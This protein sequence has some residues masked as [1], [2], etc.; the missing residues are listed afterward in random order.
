MKQN[1]RCALQRVLLLLCA[2][3][4]PT[5][6]LTVRAVT[7]GE[8]QEMEF[9]TYEITTNSRT[10]NLTLCF[11]PECDGVLTITDGYSNAQTMFQSHLYNKN[12]ISLASY[13]GDFAEIPFEKSMSDDSKEIVLQY[14]LKEGVTYYYNS[15]YALQYQTNGYYVNATSKLISAT[16][17]WSADGGVELPNEYTDMEMDV[18]YDNLQDQPVYLTFTP[19]KDGVLTAVQYGSPMLYHLVTNPLELKPGSDIRTK[20][21]G[22]Y[23]ASSN[24][25]YYTIKYELK[26]GITY[27]YN[28]EYGVQVNNTVVT[29]RNITQV[30]F[31]WRPNTDDLEFIPENAEDPYQIDYGTIYGF[32]PSITGVLTVECNRPLDYSTILAKYFL[33]SNPECSSPLLAISTFENENGTYSYK[34]EVTAGTT[35]YFKAENQYGSKVANVWFNVSE[36]VDVNLVDVLPQAGLVFDDMA[37]VNGILVRFDPETT[38]VGTATYTY[39]PEETGEETTV[40]VNCTKGLTSEYYV[41][42]IWDYYFSAAPGTDSYITLEDVNYKNYPVTGNQLSDNEA[43]TVDNGTVTIHYPVPAVRFAAEDMEWPTLY[44]YYVPGN[45]AGMVTIKFNEDVESVD[46]VDLIFGSHT[47]GAVAGETNDPSK[48]IPFTINENEITLNFTGI[49]FDELGVSEYTKATVMIYGITSVSGQSYPRGA[50]P[51]EVIIDFVDEVYPEDKEP[52]YMTATAEIL[53]PK[54][55]D[56]ISQLNEFVISWGEPVSLVQEDGLVEVQIVTE[57][58]HQLP[59]SINSDGNMVINVSQWSVAEGKPAYGLY[60]IIIPSGM[61]MNEAGEVN[62]AAALS[63]TWEDV[64]TGIGAIFTEDV[65]HEVYN[66]LGVK[67]KADKIGELTPGLYIIDGKKIYIK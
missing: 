63:Y 65:E 58:S 24:F 48:T 49:N 21:D 46:H 31:T 50:A 18:I 11:T 66:L 4:G 56:K 13:K 57:V 52:D 27:Y 14:E 34:F 37:F 17:E 51:Y 38:K 33:F 6:A 64:E 10:D 30:T 60:T 55:D 43:V 16:F 62:Q 15:F 59:V 36:T 7:F 41:V 45:E 44:A 39:T 8:A 53:S 28:S 35:Y 19:E 54:E 25:Q 42:N 40:T 5:F 20:V 67:V 23:T 32:K 61:V 26:E 9:K 3:F 2:F 47:Y 22:D 29:D 12:E 1:R